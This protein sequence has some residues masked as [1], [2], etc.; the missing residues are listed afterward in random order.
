[1]RL[2]ALSAASWSTFTPQKRQVSAVASIV[3][4]QFGH[5]KMVGSPMAAPI[6]NPS[7]MV[8]LS[9]QRQ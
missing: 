1:M 3:S 5:S 4:L 6:V 9:F 2:A 7:G 8:V